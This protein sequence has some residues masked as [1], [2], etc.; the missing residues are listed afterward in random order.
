MKTWTFCLLLLGA[1]ALPEFRAR[2]EEPPTGPVLAIIGDP[3]RAPGAG[4]FADVRAA[5][6]GA[7]GAATD[8]ALADAPREG[9]TPY[10]IDA[11]A[12]ASPAPYD[13]PADVVVADAPRDGSTPYVVDAPSS[14]DAG[15]AAPTDA[16][17]ALDAGPADAPAADGG[18]RC[19]AMY[20]GYVYRTVNGATTCC[21]QIAAGAASCVG[22]CADP[23][24][25]ACV[26]SRFCCV[27][28]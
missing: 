21:R 17:L 6:G 20:T 8:V 24:Y 7:T 12:E 15:Q 13:G 27:P 14:Y 3:W 18:W 23:V 9:S 4:T 25:G 28:N 22:A 11:P 1:C 16:W 26:A 19:R 2:E 5:D 10:L